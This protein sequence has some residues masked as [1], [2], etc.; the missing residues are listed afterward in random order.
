MVE[1]SGI[2]TSNFSNQS[3]THYAE[4]HCNVGLNFGGSSIKHQKFKQ[5][6]TYAC[7]ARKRGLGKVG[8]YDNGM[9]FDREISELCVKLSVDR[10]VFSIDKL[11][12]AND[13]WCSGSNHV[14]VEKN[15]RQLIELRGKQA[16]PKVVIN[17]IDVEDKSRTWLFMQYWLNDVGVDQVDL[18]TLHEP[19]FIVYGPERYYTGAPTYERK[20]CPLPFEVMGILADGRIAG[21]VGD[22]CAANCLG[23]AKT[24]PLKVIW[25]SPAYERFRT[26]LKNHVYPE[27][28]P[29]LKCDCWKRQF[30]PAIADLEM[31]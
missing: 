20:Y 15:I 22:D 11:G 16:T 17:K 13:N 5:L 31:A 28:S 14:L 4:L 1:K 25:K 3:L 2:L 12:P 18:S 19:K 26:A 8:W 9:L 23:N 29:C 6:L 24:T 21:C 7:E 10:I 27:G 30:K